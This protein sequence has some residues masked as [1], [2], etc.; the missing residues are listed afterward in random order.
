M[1]L[2]AVCLV[3]LALL[4]ISLSAKVDVTKNDSDNGR[5]II[6]GKQK[7]SRSDVIHKRPHLYRKLYSKKGNPSVKEYHINFE[8]HLNHCFNLYAPEFKKVSQPTK[9]IVRHYI[10]RHPCKHSYY[11]KLNRQLQFKKLSQHKQLNRIIDDLPT[12]PKT[13]SK[14][15]RRRNS[16]P[17]NRGRSILRTGVFLKKKV[18]PH[19]LPIKLRGIPE[20]LNEK[21]PTFHNRYIMDKCICYAREKIH[22]K[23]LLD[24]GERKASMLHATNALNCVSRLPKNPQPVHNH[25]PSSQHSKRDRRPEIYSRERTIRN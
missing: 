25:T 4:G 10:P 6:V 2:I 5:K 9:P 13:I 7:V 23:Q 1:K 21:P 3:S 8:H 16:F 20:K 17:N 12:K 15:F 18:V 24:E 22:E 14:V 19:G 11:R